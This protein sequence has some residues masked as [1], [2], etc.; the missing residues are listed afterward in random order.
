MSGTP[1]APAVVLVAGDPGQNQ[2]TLPGRGRV[3]A[4]RGWSPTPRELGAFWPLSR[5]A[6]YL[7]AVPSPPTNA[8]RS[9]H[10]K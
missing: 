3:E 1:H 10:H 7:V 8:A 9:V 5:E 4:R 6:K 2:N